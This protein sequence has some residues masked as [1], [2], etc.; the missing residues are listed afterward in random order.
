MYCRPDY[1]CV[2][3]IVD[4][5]AGVHGKQVH[6]LDRGGTLPRSVARPPARGRTGPGRP[7]AA[8]YGRHRL[9]P[10]VGNVIKLR[11]S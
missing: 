5:G 10:A 6:K 3:S 1:M 9:P 4:Q 11:A 8:G 7:A 2:Y